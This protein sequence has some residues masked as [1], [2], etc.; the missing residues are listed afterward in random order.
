MR[1]E[2]MPLGGPFLTVREGP[3]FSGRRQRARHR[4]S[5]SLG[6]ALTYLENQWEPLGQFLTHA[7]I[8]L[9]NNRCEN[10]IRPIA[11]GR[12]NWLFLGS[13]RGGRTAAVMYSL[14]ASCR[15]LGIDPEVYLRDV[16]VRIRVTTP[17]R[18]EELTPRSWLAAQ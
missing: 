5:S 11:V 4:E 15:A 3:F 12:R 16:L 14:I 1:A 2:S 7:L 18:I 9:D 13:P 8:P 10:S 17:A 6:K